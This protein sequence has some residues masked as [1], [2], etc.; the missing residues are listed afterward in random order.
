MDRP[1]CPA[2]TYGQDLR[3]L[4][5]PILALTLAAFTVQENVEH[6]V[7]HGH[8]IGLGALAGPE[9]PLALPVIAMVTLLVAAAGALVRWRIAALEARLVGRLD[10]PRPRGLAADRPAPGWA[11]I[12]ALRLQARFLIRPAPGR[13]PPRPA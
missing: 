3:G 6:L 10:D 4:W 12:A 1:V 7:G 8:L 5:L 2:R 13:A 9:Y 11:D